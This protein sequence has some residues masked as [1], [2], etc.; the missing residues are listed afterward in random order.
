ME[1]IIFLFTEQLGFKKVIRFAIFFLSH[2]VTAFPSAE[3]AT[4]VCC[5]VVAAGLDP[6]SSPPGLIGI[7]VF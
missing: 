6:L 1:K 3:L 7:K 5:Y 4:G 2:E